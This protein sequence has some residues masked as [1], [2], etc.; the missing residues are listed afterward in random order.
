MGITAMPHLAHLPD[1]KTVLRANLALILGLVWG[2]LAFC[3]IA[4]VV[5]DIHRWIGAW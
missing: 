3:A 1:R 4:A 5:Y 2:G